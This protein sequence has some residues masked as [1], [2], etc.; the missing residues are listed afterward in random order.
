[1]SGS[2]GEDGMLLASIATALVSTKLSG[3]F[4]KHNENKEKNLLFLISF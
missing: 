2:L 4:L 1:M 3:M